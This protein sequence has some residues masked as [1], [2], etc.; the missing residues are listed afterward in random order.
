MKNIL[1]VVLLCLFSLTLAVGQQTGAAKSEKP[2]AK[3]ETSATAGGTEAQVAKLEHDLAKA[4]LTDGAAA[5]E[6]YEADDIISTDP[7]GR[8][9][10]K[11]DD[12]KDWASGDIKLQ[13]ADISDLKVRPFGNTAVATGA[14]AIKGTFKGQDMSGNY[15]FTDTWVKRNGKWQLVASQGTKVQQQQQQ[16]Q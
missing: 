5:V 12:K 13:S 15:R 11:A 14:I 8:V 9:T 2:K 6:Q 7:S 1:V 10:T 4:I 16:Q 3:P